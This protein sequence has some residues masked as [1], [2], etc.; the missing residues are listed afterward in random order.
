MLTAQQGARLSTLTGEHNTTILSREEDLQDYFARFSKPAEKKRIGLELEVFAVNRITG[1]ALPYSGSAGIHNILRRL[2]EMHGYELLLDGS[3]IIALTKGEKMIGLEPGGQIEL[4]APPVD[5]LFEMGH[6]V[7]EFRKELASLKTD[8]PEARFITLG[9][10]PF[11][12]LQDIE[13]V[14]KTRYSLMAE[15]M[16]ERGTLSHEMMKRTATNHFNFDYENEDDAMESLRAVM[17]I[18]S[19]AT[20]LFSNSAFSEGRPNGFY[21][22]RL[23][24]WNHTAPER[25]GILTQ[26]ME[27]GKKFKDYLNYALAIPVMFIVRDKRWIPVGNCTFRDFIR[28]GFQGQKAT[29]GDF[30][31]H[32]STLFPEARFKQYLEVRGTDGLP[33]ELIPAACAFWKGLLYHPPSRKAAIDRMLRIPM[34]DRLRIHQEMPTKGWETECFFDV[35]RELIRISTSGLAA[36]NGDLVPNETLF[37]KRIENK[38]LKIGLPPGKQL[39]RAWE[40]TLQKDPSALIESL[41]LG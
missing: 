36:Q 40:T 7:L 4:S 3:N 39:C 16:K 33:S 31:L 12:A 28:N 41:S 26:F 10:Q 1:L 21:S 22:R 34:P 11:S 30:N 20:A 35:I 6:Q 17:L 37:I 24:V 29:L 2:S 13:W 14:P 27:P 19:F 23:E 15:Y 38:I 9:F 32:L 25:S 8:F 18:S 5:N